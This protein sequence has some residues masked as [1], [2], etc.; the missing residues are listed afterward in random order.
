MLSSIKFVYSWSISDVS[1]TEFLQKN[2]IYIFPYVVMQGT[3]DGPERVE[4]SVP[5]GH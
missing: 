1:V 3:F 2:N 5:Q 4:N